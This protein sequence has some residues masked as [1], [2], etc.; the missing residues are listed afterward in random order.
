[1]PDLDKPDFFEMAREPFVKKN[2][3]RL[4]RFSLNTKVLETISAE[5]IRALFQDVL[6]Y[7]VDRNSYAGQLL[8]YGM[9]PL[10]DE[11]HDAVKIPTYVAIVD[12]WDFEVKITWVRLNESEN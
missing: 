12:D 9:S 2:R 7:A 5:M 3:M 8:Y 1:M 4:G 10:F 6:V 11:L